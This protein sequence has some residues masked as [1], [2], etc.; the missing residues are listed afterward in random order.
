[1][2]LLLLKPLEEDEA[3]EDEV[4][5]L[6]S[7]RDASED[8]DN[9]DDDEDAASKGRRGLEEEALAGYIADDGREGE[10]EELIFGADVAAEVDARCDR[11]GEGDAFEDVARAGRVLTTSASAAGMRTT[12]EGIGASGADRRRFMAV[13]LPQKPCRALSD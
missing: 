5:E 1:M 4:E 11:E 3:R 6:E 13:P 12:T 8:A 2:R 10:D 9:E 7:W